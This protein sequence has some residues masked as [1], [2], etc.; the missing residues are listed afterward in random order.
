MIIQLRPASGNVAT[1][2][3]SKPVGKNFLQNTNIYEKLTGLRTN[4][5]YPSSHATPSTGVIR[6]VPSPK[7]IIEFIIDIESSFNSSI[8]F[9]R[10]LHIF[11]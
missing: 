8:S 10:I 1:E 11:I 5:A 7:A 2:V 3:R 4:F 9:S 6:T